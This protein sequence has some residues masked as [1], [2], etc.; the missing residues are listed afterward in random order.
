ME[1]FT[2]VPPAIYSGL[3]ELCSLAE[4]YAVNAETNLNASFLISKDLLP[5]HIMKGYSENLEAGVIKSIQS[6]VAGSLKALKTSQDLD[7]S[8][9]TWG[10]EKA[11]Y[12]MWEILENRTGKSCVLDFNQKVTF[13]YSDYYF[14][15]TLFYTYGDAEFGTAWTDEKE[16]VLEFFANKSAAYFDSYFSSTQ[17]F[18]VYYS[19]Y[20]G[21][22]SAIGTIVNLCTSTFDVECSYFQ[23]VLNHPLEF[24]NVDSSFGIKT[25]DE[26][27]SLSGGIQDASV[28]PSFEAYYNLCQPSSCQYTEIRGNNGVEIIVTLLSLYGGLTQFLGMLIDYTI[29]Y[30]YAPTPIKPLTSTFV[31]SP[32]A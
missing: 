29:G 15:E 18:C 3:T 14:N 13:N 23:T 9:S 11:F 27:Y 17:M 22:Y 31:H 10:E 2:L 24:F 26:L 4:N 30:Y 12:N 20:F 28:E 1:K 5:E 21:N 8:Q 25:V 16:P 7:M 6:S 32:R 19:Y